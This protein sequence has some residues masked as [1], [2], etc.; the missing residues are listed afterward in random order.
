[1]SY[2]LEQQQQQS[3]PPPVYEVVSRSSGGGSYGPVIG[4]I[5]VI[6]VLGVIAGIVGRLCSGR[7]IFGYGYDF[8][9][10]IERKCAS[11]IDGRVELRPPPPP[12]AAPAAGPGPVD[13]PVTM[14]NKHGS[15]PWTVS[16]KAHCLCSEMDW[17]TV[18]ISFFV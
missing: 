18:Q 12:V 5:A 16:M 8:E 6:A 10:W 17:T 15:S 2:P 7:R 1:M 9:G 14:N 4:V 11:C 13:E 3:P